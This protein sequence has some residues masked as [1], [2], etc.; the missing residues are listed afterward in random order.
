[1]GGAFAGQFPAD[2]Y[3]H[4]TE[5]ATGHVLQPGCC[6]GNEFEIGLDLILDVPLSEQPVSPDPARPACGAA[7]GRRHHAP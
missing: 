6:Y 3:S 7:P 5:L 4:L 2:Q 1:M